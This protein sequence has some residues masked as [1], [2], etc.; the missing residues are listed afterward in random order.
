MTYINVLPKHLLGGTEE[1]HIQ[2]QLVWP[3]L[4]PRIEPGTFQL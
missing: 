2:S 1:N 4:G 3:G